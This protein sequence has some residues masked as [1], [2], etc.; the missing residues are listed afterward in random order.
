MVMAVNN[1]KG[2]MTSVALLEKP[3]QKADEF[4]APAFEGSDE[5]LPYLQML[6]QQDPGQAGFFITT[7]NAEAVEFRPGAGWE[8]H[9]TRFQSG[10]TA[11]GYRSLS[12]RMLVL[13]KS[14]LMMFDRDSGDYIDLYQKSVYDRGTMVLKIRYLVYLVD[15]AN[16]LLHEQPLLFT[17]KGAMCGDFGEVYQRFRREMS[18]AFGQARGTHRPRSDQFLALSVLAMTVSP[19][20]KGRD[21][22]SWVC[23]IAGVNHPTP[24]NWLEWFV[25]YDEATKL[26]VYGVFADWADFG[27]PEREL[28]AQ[29]RRAAASADDL[30]TELTYEYS[31]DSEG[32]IEF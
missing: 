22:K 23:G 4:D 9:T 1:G 24:E 31:L 28:E 21:K 8:A 12:V 16:Q 18:R 32:E 27:Q 19:I 6:N 30:P 14:A 2:K 29:Q 11:A 17:T 26:R 5:S 13:R 7:E 25:G 3:A 20:L 10:E 15:G